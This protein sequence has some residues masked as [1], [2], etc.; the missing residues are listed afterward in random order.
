MPTLRHFQ[1]VCKAVEQRLHCQ[2]SGLFCCRTKT[3]TE[4]APDQSGLSTP[5]LNIFA[6]INSFSQFSN[7]IFLLSPLN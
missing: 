5:G 4:K 1:F 2:R 6:L 3:E 7:N